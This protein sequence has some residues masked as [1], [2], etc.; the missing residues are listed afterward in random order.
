MASVEPCWWEHRRESQK[1]RYKCTYN[2]RAWS[3]LCFFVPLW[4]AVRFAW[5][6]PSTAL[7]MFVEI[8]EKQICGRCS[9]TMQ[10]HV[11]HKNLFRVMQPKT[12][13]GA[14]KGKIGLEAILGRTLKLKIWESSDLL[15]NGVWDQFLKHL[16]LRAF[17]S[18]PSQLLTCEW[19]LLKGLWP[20]TDF[21]PWVLA[22]PLATCFKKLRRYWQTLQA[23]ISPFVSPFASGLRNWSLV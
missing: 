18:H 10:A 8:L 17:A 4:L 11:D 20:F 23:L 5:L 15:R 13:N 21:D 3:G 14:I 22:K 2:G 16:T 1:N 19:K 7:L 9:R 6:G 12:K